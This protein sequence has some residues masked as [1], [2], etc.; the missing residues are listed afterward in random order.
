MVKGTLILLAVLLATC[1]LVV[2][3]TGSV[4]SFESAPP[5]LPITASFARSSGDEEKHGLVSLGQHSLGPPGSD[6]IAIAFDNAS[7]A[8]YVVTGFGWLDVVSG[9]TLQVVK[10]IYLGNDSGPESIAYDSR[11]ATIFVGAYPGNLLVL[12]TSSNKVVANISVGYEPLTLAFDYQTG[13]LYAGMGIESALSTGTSGDYNVTVVNGSTYAISQFASYPVVPTLYPFQII[14]DPYTRSLIVMGEPGPDPWTD[15]AAFSETNGSVIWFDGGNLNGPTY[16]GETLDLSDGEVYLANCGNNS[17]VGLN[18]SSGLYEDSFP[19]PP[20]SGECASDGALSFDDSSDKVL[21]GEPSAQIQALNV[22]SRTLS[23][24]LGIGGQPGA[25]AFDDALDSPVVLSTD[26]AVLAVLSA[27]A[28]FVRS[29]ATVGGG[30]TS[31]AFDPTSNA[32]YVTGSDNVT[33]LN[34]TSRQVLGRISVGY[35]PSAVL[36]DPTDGDVFV[37]N[38]DSG[39]VTVISSVNNTA[40]ASML[41]D[42]NPYAL[43]WDN[44]TDTVFVAC[45]N[46][47]SNPSEGY[48]DGISGSSLLIESRFAI[49]EDTFPDGLA[50]IPPTGELIVAHADAEY[51]PFNLS[52][53]SSTTGLQVGSV[54]LPEGA[55]PGAMVFDNVTGELYVANAGFG[56]NG[57]NTP[58]DYVVNVSSLTVVGQFSV[59]EYQAGLTAFVP[60]GL[61]FAASLD[62]DTVE[63]ASTDSL[64]ITGVAALPPGSMPLSLCYDTDDGVL[65][66]ADWGSDSLTFLTY[67]EVYQVQITETGLP[68]GTNWSLEIS[69][70]TLAS[71]SPHLD[72]FEANGTYNFTVGAVSGFTPNPASGELLVT[73]LEENVTI[74]FEKQ[75]EITF[76][77]AGLP[78]GTRWAVTLNGSTTSSSTSLLDFAEPNGT[79]SYSVDGVAGYTSTVPTGNVTVSGMNV[80]VAVQFAPTPPEMYSVNFTESGLPSG[81]NWSVTLNGSTEESES[82]GI[83]FTEPNGSY[84]FTVGLSAAY[85]ASP[86]SGTVNVSGKSVNETITFSSV[87]YGLSCPG[88]YL[89]VFTA[90]GLP[91]GTMWS[92]TINGSIVSGTTS[93]LT[94]R[95][96]NGTYPFSVGQVTGYSVNPRTGSVTVSGSGLNKNITF[97]SIT[98]SNPTLWGLSDVDWYILVGALV[99][100]ALV[101][102]VVPVMRHRR[103]KVPPDAATP[104]RPGR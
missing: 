95:L 37:A 53:L 35:L 52:V 75:F 91:S 71:T 66:V 82:G 25:F 70:T 62:N 1:G 76:E 45:M 94:T 49:G 83:E 9:E 16:T 8:F 19:L 69:G 32:L 31:I 99:A 44:Q 54:T 100:V 43:A 58:Y 39:N 74:A 26:T 93:V 72:V 50:Y 67:E 15:V 96:Q 27:N 55:E 11:T 89:V 12:A 30:P 88:K 101:A 33:V 61:L 40:V 92:L 97:T 41:V 86:G 73:G 13:D 85:T 104:T 84:P 36:Y 103:G 81:T 24:P 22:S 56:N 17:V 59:G 63:V 7:N 34:A 3:L 57:V 2:T 60:E 65:I 68:P 48:V 51:A 4:H 21:I 46:L 14:S 80:T 98:S 77:A 20:R 10:S 102:I 78:I 6:P 79:Y 38:T 42:P 5:H 90:S 64:N 29:W 28:S 87:C 23:S 47:T 18:V